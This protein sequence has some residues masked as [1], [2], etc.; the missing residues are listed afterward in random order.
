MRTDDNIENHMV[1]NTPDAPWNQPDAPE[2]SAAERLARE[3]AERDAKDRARLVESLHDLADF[4]EERTDIALP[5]VLAY[6]MSY[7]SLMVPNQRTTWYIGLDGSGIKW[8]MT[9]SIHPV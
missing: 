6:R 3:K 5:C 9:I 7:S 2:E 4:V 1:L 8:R